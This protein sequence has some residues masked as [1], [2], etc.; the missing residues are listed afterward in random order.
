[1]KKVKVTLDLKIVPLSYQ[2]G[3]KNGSLSL[4]LTV[5]QIKAALGFAPNRYSGD[6]KVNHSWAFRVGNSNCGIWDYKGVRWSFGGPKEIFE[7]IFGADNVR[8]I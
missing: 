2:T 3:S 1:M 8:G 5:N 6:G 4:T 7:A